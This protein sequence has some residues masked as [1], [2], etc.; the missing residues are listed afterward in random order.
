MLNQSSTTPWG[1][2]GIT[3]SFFTLA[4]DGGE[5]STSCPGCFTAKERAPG[6]QWTVGWVEPTASLDNVEYRTISCPC[7]ELKPS[8]PVHHYTELYAIIYQWKWSFVTL[9]TLQN[10]SGARL[11][12]LWFHIPWSGII[13]INMQHRVIVPVS[14]D[15]RKPIST[16]CVTQLS[17]LLWRY[18]PNK[19]CFNR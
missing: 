12:G 7:Q 16:S 17:P 10:W 11:P 19:F 3:P 1:S 9:C 2:G 14:P 6:V 15:G 8:H 4:L 18:I 13:S 5:W